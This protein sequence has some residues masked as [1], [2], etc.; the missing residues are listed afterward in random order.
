MTGIDGR[1]AAWHRFDRHFFLAFVGCCWVAIT[2]GFAPAV[3]TRLA[4]T[5]DYDAPW[6]L[7]IHVWSFVAWMTILTL[8]IGFIRFRRRDLH[9]LLGPII[10][11]LIPVMAISAIATEIYSER[12]YAAK[13][14]EEFRFFILPLITV[15]LFTITACGGFIMRHDPPAHKRMILLATSVI[16]SAATFR[17]WGA[18]IF[19]AFGFN[20]W[21]MSDWLGPTMLIVSAVLYDTL[22]RGRVHRVLAIG[23]PL[24][25]AAFAASI[26]IYWS[27]WWLALVRRGFGN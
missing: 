6:A 9:R 15:V 10:L 1:F 14:P 13:D 8:Q 27:D 22:T 7:V 23:A 12:F 18:A 2:F 20:A 17:W 5:P 24:Y 11:A 16:L 4:G 3:K 21:L 26:A 25:L 19:A